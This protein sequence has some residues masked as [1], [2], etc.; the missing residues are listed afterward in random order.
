MRW[1][2]TA[3]FE[4]SDMIWVAGTV[5][6]V[7]MLL[8]KKKGLF[9]WPSRTGS[10]IQETSVKRAA[11][12]SSSMECLR[13]GGPCTVWRDLNLLLRAVGSQQ[14]VLWWGGTWQ[15]T[16]ALYRSSWEPSEGEQEDRRHEGQGMESQGDGG[17]WRGG[18]V[19]LSPPLG[20]VAGLIIKLT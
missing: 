18:K 14:K 19:F 10:L 13:S 1:K 11:E 7:N 4:Q 8:W 9:T 20:T 2:N 15:V 3:S 12:S 17:L 5:L 16:W 6:R